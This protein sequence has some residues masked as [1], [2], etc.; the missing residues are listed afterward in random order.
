MVG[1]AV[2]ASGGCSLRSMAVNAIV[3]T[4][5]NPDVY[6]S[7][8]D[9]ELARAALPFLLKTIESIL[10]AEPDQDQALVFAC[11]GFTLYGNAFLQVDADVA[12]WEGDYDRSAALR[13]RTWRVYVRARDYC[14]RSLELRYAG[15]GAGLRDDPTAALA[16]TNA[17]DVEVLYLLAAAWGL[18]ISN[19]LDQPSLIAGLPAV[20][21]LFG[22]ALELDEDFERGSLHAALIVLESLPPE[23][24]GSPERARAHFERA[25]E[26]SDGLDAG[27]YVAFANGVSVPEENRAEFQE[28]LTTA[29]AIDPDEETSLR[30]LNLTNQRLARSLLEQVD[31]LFFDPLETEETL[32]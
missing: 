14:L 17:E 9:P 30:L 3:P 26:L 4:L 21:A 6:R 29:L 15:I 18:A 5:A 1:I 20:R 23:L 24:G 25:V 8:E 13:D 31:D 2:V 7:E 11:T 10:D 28:L 32:P 27:P 19:A 12:E 16:D 22:R